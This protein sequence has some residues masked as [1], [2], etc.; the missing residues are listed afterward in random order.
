[1][2]FDFGPAASFFMS[3]FALI[4]FGGF[5]SCVNVP[6]PQTSRQSVEDLSFPSP[7][8]PFKMV[9]D[10][11]ADHVWNDLQTSSVISIYS[12]C[13]EQADTHLMSA[14]RQVRSSFDDVLEST[15]TDVQIGER[16]GKRIMTLGLIDGLKVKTDHRVF[17][18][19][20]CQLTI[21]YVSAPQKFSIHAGL[22]ERFVE[23]FKL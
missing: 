15:V 7:D 14:V 1:M 17:K 12:D 23:K 16:L 4:A 18:W 5:S 22:F 10:N 3:T 6:L 19:K 9:S 21:S 8:A 11:T 2:R 20:G 13:R